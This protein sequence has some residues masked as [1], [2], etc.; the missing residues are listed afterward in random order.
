MYGVVLVG[1]LE[2]KITSTVVV[3]LLVGLGLVCL[4]FSP[5]GPNC[6]SWLVGALVLVVAGQLASLWRRYRWLRWPCLAAA[7]L[8]TVLPE[9]LAESHL[10]LTALSMLLLFIWA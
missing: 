3:G 6:A 4:Y 5:W 10:P 9:M 1:R 8:S 7:L 2:Y